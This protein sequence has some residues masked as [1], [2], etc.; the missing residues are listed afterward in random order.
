M[1]G[2]HPDD[3]AT[4]VARS[5]RPAKRAKGSGVSEKQGD[6]IEALFANPDKAL[7]NPLGPKAKVLAPPPEIVTNVQGSSAGAGSGEFHVYKAS[8]RREYERLRAMDEDVEREKADRDWEEKRAEAK[9]KEDARLSKNR[10]RRE[11]QKARQA[12]TKGNG[13]ADV[14]AEGQANGSQLVK[15]RLVPAKTMPTQ[16][17]AEDGNVP[18]ADNAVETIGLTFMEDD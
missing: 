1:A 13:V 4:S 12:K 11:K 15:K 3:I 6:E 2:T 9:S 17:T 16:D 14:P 7:A 10:A 5:G 18:V 8:R